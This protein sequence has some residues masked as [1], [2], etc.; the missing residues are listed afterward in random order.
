MCGNCSKILNPTLFLLKKIVVI[1]P[2]INKI[3]VR[4]ANREDPDQVGRQIKIDFFLYI[5]KT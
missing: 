4:I 1:R 3:L 5:V 2:G